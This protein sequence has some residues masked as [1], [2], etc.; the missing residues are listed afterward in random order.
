[1]RRVYLSLSAIGMILAACGGSDGGG[2]PPPASPQPPNQAAMAITPDNS[3]PAARVA[4]GA[5]VQ[6]A[7]TG[8]MVGGTGLV[9]NP[10]G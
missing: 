6:S 3:K 7:G 5:T 4:Y 1:M 2:P 10:G 8:E 9:S